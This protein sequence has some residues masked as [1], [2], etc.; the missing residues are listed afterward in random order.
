M[1]DLFLHALGGGYIQNLRMARESGRTSE[2]GLSPTGCTYTY[3]DPDTGLFFFTKFVSRKIKSFVTPTPPEKSSTNSGGKGVLMS[4]IIVFFSKVSGAGRT[5][6]TKVSHSCI[7]YHR[8]RCPGSVST[9]LCRIRTYVIIE[10]KGLPP[11]GSMKKGNYSS[12]CVRTL[13]PFFFSA[14]PFGRGIE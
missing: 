13:P 14:E 8:G 6:P 3:L 1:R 5:K 2:V 10:V 7:R 4:C 12:P 11:S 9:G